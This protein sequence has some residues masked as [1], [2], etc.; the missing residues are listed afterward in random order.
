MGTHLSWGEASRHNSENTKFPQTLLVHVSNDIRNYWNLNRN[1]IA[2]YQNI[3]VASQNISKHS[4]LVINTNEEYSQLYENFNNTYMEYS[5]QLPEYSDVSD[6]LQMSRTVIYW[7]IPLLF[8]NI[9][10]I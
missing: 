8:K 5:M 1:H 3:F 4:H 9:P 6:I 2:C 7:N 10:Y